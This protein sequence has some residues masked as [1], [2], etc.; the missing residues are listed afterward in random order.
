[1]Q[2]VPKNYASPG[3]T[4]HVIARARL[5]TRLNFPRRAFH[6]TCN[7]AFYYG[8]FVDFCLVLNK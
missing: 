4:R 3:D 7:N 8:T 5:H 1:M 2:D 6:R